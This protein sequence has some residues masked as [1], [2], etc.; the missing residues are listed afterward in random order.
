[1]FTFIKEKFCKTPSFD[2]TK[3]YPLPSYEN[4]FRENNTKLTLKNDIDKSFLVFWT[5]LY[6]EAMKK[7]ENDIDT[8][9]YHKINDDFKKNSNNDLKDN[10]K[11][12]DEN[13][14]KSN[15]KLKEF[16]ENTATIHFP[17]DSD[18][19]SQIHNNYE[20]S[21]NNNNLQQL[22]EDFE[23]I[24]ESVK[25][26]YNNTGGY[27]YCPCK[28]IQPYNFL[29]KSHFPEDHFPLITND[30]KKYTKKYGISYAMLLS[31]NN[32]TEV[33]SLMYC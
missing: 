1:M 24:N 23:K 19:Y 2:E 12:F 13:Y 30:D 5:F 7:I 21:L 22:D 25:F 26:M 28:S 29:D 18:I 32:D 27:L 33:K 4:N 3:H 17:E 15:K 6:V 10:K 16:V 9:D 8:V 11:Y 20:E 14:I 31:F